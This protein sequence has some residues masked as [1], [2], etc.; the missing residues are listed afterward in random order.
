MSFLPFYRRVLNEDD[1]DVVSTIYT[2][3]L[4]II[5]T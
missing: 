1:D 5:H 4:Y 2:R 3:T